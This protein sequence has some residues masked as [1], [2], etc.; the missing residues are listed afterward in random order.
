MCN[1]GGTS[2]DTPVERPVVGPG[3]WE[4]CMLDEQER[5]SLLEIESH[6][7]EHDEELVRAFEILTRIGG[8][9][10]PSRRRPAPAPRRRP[11]LPPGPSSRHRPTPP[12]SLPPAPPSR[13]APHPAAARERS[14]DPPRHDA[15]LMR[16]VQCMLATAVVLPL[17]A[18]VVALFSHDAATLVMCATFGALAGFVGY[19]A[20]VTARRR[21][22]H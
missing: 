21:R 5:R 16:I 9:R 20:A 4:A 14:A 15:A 11:A 1:S 3:E 10:P 19:A 17:V 13:S 8:Q 22:R 6:L 7:R 12:P 2:N 18:F